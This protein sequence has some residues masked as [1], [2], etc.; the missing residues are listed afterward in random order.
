[1]MAYA[2]AE[3]ADAQRLVAR[4]IHLYQWGRHLEQGLRYDINNYVDP[5]TRE[6]D[7]RRLEREVANQVV[8]RR[9]I[10]RAK[11]RVEALAETYSRLMG[12]SFSR[13]RPY[14]APMEGPRMQRP[15]FAALARDWGRNE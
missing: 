8:R 5:S 12:T 10:D 1:M 7:K 3:I 11:D 15:Q 6:R 13:P 2:E 4:A 9:D 14:G